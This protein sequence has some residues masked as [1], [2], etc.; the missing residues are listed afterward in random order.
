[1]SVTSARHLEGAYNLNP[2]GQAPGV[3]PTAVGLGC[4]SDFFLGLCTGGAGFQYNPNV[5]GQIGVFATAWS[6]NYNSLQASINRHF[7]NGLQFQAAYTWSRYFDYT[8]N[9]ENSAFNGPGFNDFN[10]AQNYGPSANDAPQRLVMNFV[11]TLP[12]YKYGHHWRRSP[13]AG[14]SQASAPTSTVFQSRLQTTVS[15]TCSGHIPTHFSLRRVSPMP[16]G[17]RYRSTTIPGTARPS[18]G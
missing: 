5:Y 7:S 9:L 6:S 13:M 11:Y 15:G 16:Q 4:T 3:N 17:L 18:S 10:N 14:T 8:S 2:A 12:I 1:M